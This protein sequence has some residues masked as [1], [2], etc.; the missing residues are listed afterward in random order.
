MKAKRFIGETFPFLADFVLNSRYF[1]KSDPTQYGELEVLKKYLPSRGSY[2]ELGGWMP[3]TYSNSFALKKLK[4]SYKGTSIDPTPGLKWLWRLFRPSDKFESI[5]VV[6]HN[7]NVGEVTL[8][9]FRRRFAVV[10]RI[11]I[12]G[13]LPQGA[14]SLGSDVYGVPTK[15]RV[16]AVSL[17]D[18]FQSHLSDS[19]RLTLLMTDIEGLDFDVLSDLR[20]LQHQLPRFVLAEDHNSAIE[21][22]L[23][24]LGYEFLEQVGPN[25]FFRH[26]A[27]LGQD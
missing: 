12:D 5:A 22:L 24:S 6:S 2:I 19:D 11:S 26:T 17:L 25:K 18:L 8:E 15:V 23:V 4:M 27:V 13:I 10:N 7:N 20:L 1:F 9:C 21:D 3:V 14:L 16:P